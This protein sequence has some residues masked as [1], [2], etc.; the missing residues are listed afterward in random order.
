MITACVNGCRKA[1]MVMVEWQGE[2][3]VGGEAESEL[4]DGE[5]RAHREREKQRKNS[6]DSARTD[7]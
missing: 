6:N 5:H 7:V 2:S 3:A 4:A 1:S